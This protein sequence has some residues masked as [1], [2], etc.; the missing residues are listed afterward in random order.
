MKVLDEDDKAQKAAEE[1]AKRKEWKADTS[2]LEQF[3]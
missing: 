1:A 3:R 2:K